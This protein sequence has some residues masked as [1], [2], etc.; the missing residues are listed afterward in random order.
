MLLRLTG[1]TAF[2]AEES[3]IRTALRAWAKQSTPPVYRY[4]LVDLNADGIDDAV[5]LLTDKAYCGSGGCTMVIA[6]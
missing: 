4:A 3:S 5:V 2:A 1:T 6:H